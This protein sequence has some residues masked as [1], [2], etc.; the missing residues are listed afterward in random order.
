MRN[1]EGKKQNNVKYGKLPY[2]GDMPLPQCTHRWAYTKTYGAVSFLL[3][4]WDIIYRPTQLN[5]M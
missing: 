1:A 3:N 2:A 4:D 5:A